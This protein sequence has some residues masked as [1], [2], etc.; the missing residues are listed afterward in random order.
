MSNETFGSF[1]REKREEQRVSLRQ[2]CNELNVDP[3]RWSKVE[4]GVLQ[5]PGDDDTLNTMAKLLAIKKNSP[6][7]AKMKDLAVLGRGEIPKDIMEDEELVACLPMV[8]R[9]LRREKPSKDQLLSLADLIR[10]SNKGDDV[11]E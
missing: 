7:W 6:D 8:F 11:D 3:S 2:F 1:I 10:H 5:P 4:R 9:T